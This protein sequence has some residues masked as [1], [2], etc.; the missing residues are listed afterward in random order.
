MPPSSDPLSRR[1]DGK[2]ERQSGQSKRRGSVDALLHPALPRSRRHPNARSNAVI[3]TTILPI[4]PLLAVGADAVSD[5]HAVEGPVARETWASDRRLLGL[6][7]AGRERA[8]QPQL[9]GLLVDT[10][11]ARNGPVRGSAMLHLDGKF[12][13]PGDRGGRRRAHGRELS[14]GRRLMNPIVD[15]LP[16]R[17]SKPIDPAIIGVAD[18]REPVANR[19]RGDPVRAHLAH[20]RIHLG[21]WAEPGAVHSH[22]KAPMIAAQ[23]GTANST[24]LTMPR[25]AR[26]ATARGFSLNMR[27]TGGAVACSPGLPHHRSCDTPDGESLGRTNHAATCC[28]HRDPTA[29]IT[30]YTRN[31]PSACDESLSVRRNDKDTVG[32]W[33]RDQAGPPSGLGRAG[34]GSGCV[35]RGSDRPSR[36]TESDLTHPLSSSTSATSIWI[37]TCSS[38]GAAGVG[39]DGLEMTSGGRCPPTKSARSPAALQSCAPSF[40]R[41]RMCM[42]CSIAQRRRCSPGESMVSSGRGSAVM[43]PGCPEL[44]P[45]RRLASEHAAGRPSRPQLRSPVQRGCVT[46]N[47]SKEVSRPQCEPEPSDCRQL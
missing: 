3:G 14:H 7:D 20:F 36:P 26:L 40:H 25:T 37:C 43:L 18:D 19:Q 11:T 35:S 41:N 27:A 1:I 21:G 16:L 28:W 23:S 8:V 10:E 33:G 5:P 9:A 46:K 29:R 4:V 44:A 13:V 31:R 38:S 22:S 39:P 30:R 15:H 17:Q 12:D 45:E 34:C 2:R 47:R 32:S 6:A 24:P 42:S